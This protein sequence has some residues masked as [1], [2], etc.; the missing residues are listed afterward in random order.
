MTS[1]SLGLHTGLTDE[2]LARLLGLQVIP[3]SSWPAGS[4]CWLKILALVMVLMVKDGFGGGLDVGPD[5]AFAG[6][7]CAIQG[8]TDL[9]HF[10]CGQSHH[11]TLAVSPH[12]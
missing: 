11:L 10:K 6:A 8:L 12:I 5:A 4:T 1:L 2:G 7:D 9:R 3:A